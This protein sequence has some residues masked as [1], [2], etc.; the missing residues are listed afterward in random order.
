M[1][2]V[3]KVII[4]KQVLIILCPNFQ[5]VFREP[6]RSWDKGWVQPCPCSSCF[7]VCCHARLSLE[8][9]VCISLDPRRKNKFQLE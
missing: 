9:R 6:L 1:S 2:P 8:E 4:V 5:R 7:T 3:L